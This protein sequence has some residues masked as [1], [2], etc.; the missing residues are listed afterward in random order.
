M[1]H[2]REYLESRIK[3]LKEDVERHK[4]HLALIKRLPHDNPALHEQEVHEYERRRD[5]DQ[6]LLGQKYGELALLDTAI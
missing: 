3:M 4:Q 1:S 6:Q 5:L 2:I